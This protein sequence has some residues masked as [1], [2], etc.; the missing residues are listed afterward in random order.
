MLNDKIFQI[1]L[2]CN[3]GKVKN[4]FKLEKNSFVY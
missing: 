3:A 1:I 2:K 4:K